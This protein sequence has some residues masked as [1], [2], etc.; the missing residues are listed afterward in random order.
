MAL[1]PHLPEV[2]KR[3]RRLRDRRHLEACGPVAVLRL[4]F[5]SNATS[6]SVALMWGP[7]MR[8]P[9]GIHGSDRPVRHD[10]GRG[11]MGTWG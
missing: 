5:V 2:S 3:P 6:A 10:D 7:T 9:R 8:P 4:H 11:V 1:D